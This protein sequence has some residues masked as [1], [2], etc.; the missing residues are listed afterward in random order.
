MNTEKIIISSGCSYALGLDSFK[1]DNIINLH[2]TNVKNIGAPASSI[3]F[4]KELIIHS[5]NHALNEG[6]PA[7]NI[8][9]VFDCTQMGRNTKR[10]PTEFVN[11]I[12]NNISPKMHSRDWGNMVFDS[13][14]EG[15]FKLNNNLYTTF[16]DGNLNKFPYEVKQWIEDETGYSNKKDIIDHI[17][18]YIETILII[19]NFLKNKN[20]DY[21]A[22]FMS[23]VI[24]GWYY[25]SFL[26]HRYSGNKTYTLPNLKNDLNISEISEPI[27]ILFN[28]IDFDKFILYKNDNQ[29]FGGL[30][31][32]TIDN[33]DKTAF[34]DCNV[35][36]EDSRL[37][38]HP[39]Q[40]V[41]IDFEKMY[42]A[43][44]LE[45]FLNK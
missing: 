28:T 21:S 8:Y 25:D 32:F 18:E 11:H 26:K 20:I 45:S 4:T 13:Y 12:L 6:F 23:N 2:L 27:H 31:E 10:V 24:E 16:S 34:K 43:Q 19:Q 39:N 7:D 37:G 44:K 30:D 35:E 5:V 14:C 38:M 3:Q 41:Q 40:Q 22:F 9:I 33:Y 42:L 29:T 36:I 15:Y 17:Q 1:N